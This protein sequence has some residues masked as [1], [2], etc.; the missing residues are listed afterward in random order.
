M[1]MHSGKHSLTCNR[2]PRA[3][4]QIAVHNR[5]L[6]KASRDSCVGARFYSDINDSLISSTHDFLRLF[7]I[8][9]PWPAGISLLESRNLA[10]ANS[11]VRNCG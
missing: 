10:F 7:L 3:V 9:D 6:N 4:E 5:S 11:L 2:F 1:W 8:T